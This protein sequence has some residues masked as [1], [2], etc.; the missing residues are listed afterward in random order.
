MTEK[1]S[2]VTSVQSVCDVTQY[3]FLHF[4]SNL[5]RL[6]IAR[7]TETVWLQSS[8][9]NP[10]QRLS[11]WVS[12]H[13]HTHSLSFLGFQQCNMYYF[14]TLLGLVVQSVISTHFLS[15]LLQAALHG[16]RFNNQTLHLAWH[17]A[18][19]A[20][21]TVDA[22]E[23]EAEEDEVGGLLS[24]LHA[25]YMVVAYKERGPAG[26][27]LFLPRAQTARINLQRAIFAWMEK[28]GC[29]LFRYR[30]KK[31]IVLEVLEH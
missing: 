25:L 17:K 7:S 8:L 6:K 30:Q 13:T 31:L 28:R 2:H 11:R 24:L 1:T 4:W 29:S 10:G 5:E 14:W 20:L 19:M 27:V 21:S 15:V 18:A 16:V 26:W 3:V 23:A 22:D 12:H 9:T